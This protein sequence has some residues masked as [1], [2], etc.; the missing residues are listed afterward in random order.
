MDKQ[1]ETRHNKYAPFWAAAMIIVG[2]AGL[3]TIWFDLGAFWK[4]YVLDIAGPAWNYILFRGLYTKYSENAWRRFFTPTRTFLIF[5]LVCTGIEMG[6][7]FDVY[8]A[9]FDPWDLI[10]YVSLLLPL[11]ILDLKQNKS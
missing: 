1:A 10:A 11:Y 2:L 5:I 4:S 8:D 9:T 6:Q 3:S 7:Y